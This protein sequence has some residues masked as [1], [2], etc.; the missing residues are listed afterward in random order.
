MSRHVC[1]LI[2]LIF[3]GCGPEIPDEFTV[4]GQPLEYW[5]DALSDSQSEMRARAVRALGNVGPDV[6]EIVPALTEAL[7]DPDPGI[8][9]AAVLALLK[10]GPA[11]QDAVP[12]LTQ[13]TTDSDENVRQLAAKALEKIQKQ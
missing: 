4:S 2:A 3:A 12:A 7:A 13:A 9:A 5:L 11:A 10:F 8:R 6:P 1:V